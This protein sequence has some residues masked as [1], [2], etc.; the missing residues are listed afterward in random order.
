MQK[1][2]PRGQALAEEPNVL[3]SNH[4]TQLSAQFMGDVGRIQLWTRRL[5][6]RRREVFL[7]RK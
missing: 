4:L 1:I 7:Q 3:S 2:G 6:L 5:G